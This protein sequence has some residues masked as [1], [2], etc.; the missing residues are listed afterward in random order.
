M[1]LMSM[2]KI[3][4]IIENELINKT[5]KLNKVIEGLKNSSF[6]NI[7]RDLEKLCD[8]DKFNYND[9]NE[10]YMI[11]RIMN[12]M[13][14]VIEIEIDVDINEKNDLYDLYPPGQFY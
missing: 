3:V 14:E 12:S 1:A 6:D 13:P 8:K 5:Y 9:R 4:N 10:I 2:K 11:L 7:G